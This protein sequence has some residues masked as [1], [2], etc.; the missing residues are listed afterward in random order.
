MIKAEILH[1]ESNLTYL[2][3]E[4]FRKSQPLNDRIVKLRKGLIYQLPSSGA[5][6]IQKLAFILFSLVFVFLWN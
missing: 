1:G 6:S 5:I 3:M 4:N 2:P